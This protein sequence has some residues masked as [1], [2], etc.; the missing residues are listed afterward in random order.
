MAIGML[1]CNEML[2]L[3]SWLD[4][5]WGVPQMRMGPGGGRTGNVN[6]LHSY[7]SG[8]NV[9]FLLPGFP[10]TPHATTNT[11]SSGAAP[12]PMVL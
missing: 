11:P 2:G 7:T 9:L 4:P 1:M 10:A 6:C 8:K 5:R 3:Q 12:L